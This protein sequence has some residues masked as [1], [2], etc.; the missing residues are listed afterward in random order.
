[1]SRLLSSRAFTAA[2][3][4]LDWFYP[5]HCYHCGLPLARFRNRMLCPECVRHLEKGRLIG[6]L[7]VVCGLPLPGS[8]GTE[9]CLSCRA[10]HPPF[11]RARAFFPYSGPAA[12]I[13]RSYK[14]HGNYFLGPRLMRWVLERHGVPPGVEGYDVLVPVP[15]HPRRHRERGYN[16]STL[17]ARVLARH[18]GRP[19]L[20]RAL[21]RTRHTDQQALLPRPERRENVRGAFSP[22]PQEVAGKDLLLIDDVMTTGA[23]A[24]ECAAVLRRAGANNVSVLTLVSAGR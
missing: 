16:Q 7:C 8:D 17:L 3:A 24:G 23:T 12:S 14:Y 1:M 10:L 6:P 9:E 18:S 5:P 22:G 11:F 2:G 4:L 21:R 19:L 13:V 15:L 20:P